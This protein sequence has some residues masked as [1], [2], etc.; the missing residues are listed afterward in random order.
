[1]SVLPRSSA[2]EIG[3]S[4]RSLELERSDD[5]V[6]EDDDGIVYFTR[7]VEPRASPSIARSR[8]IN[9]CPFL[10]VTSVIPYLAQLLHMRVLV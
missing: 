10:A 3:P 7:I 5:A 1:M 9:L 4:R 2:R 8:I 6:C